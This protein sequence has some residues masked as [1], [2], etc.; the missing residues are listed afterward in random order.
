MLKMVKTLFSLVLLLG[1]GL[2][3]NAQEEE[4]PASAASVYNDALAT[5]KEKNYVDA[6]GMFEQA[7]ELADTTKEIDQKVIRLANK[8]GSICAYRAGTTLRKDGDLE[9]AVEVFNKGITMNPEYAGNYLGKAQALEDMEGKTKEAIMA[10]IAAGEQAAAS[11]RNKDKAPKLLE[12]AQNFSAIA[13]IK[14]DDFEKTIELADVYLTAREEA[15]DGFVA[16]YY[17]AAALNRLDRNDEALPMIQMSVG[18]LPEG[19]DQDKYHLLHGI[20]QQALGNNDEAIAAYEMVKG[21]KYKAAAE[22]R[23]A[24]LKQ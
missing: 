10:Y 16:A 4:A 22:S 17:K 18:A 15:G 20:I 9:K 11:S 12:K 3:V 19:E 5:L 14:E 23:I 24:A 6:F 13:F 2:T 21:E 7:L 8:N 1:L